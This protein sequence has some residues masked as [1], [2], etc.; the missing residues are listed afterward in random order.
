[1][2]ANSVQHRNI[3]QPTSNQLVDS[4]A[5][6]LMHLLPLP[7][8]RAPT[9]PLLRAVGLPLKSSRMNVA[10]CAR[11]VRLLSSAMSPSSALAAAVKSA[12]A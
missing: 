1:M 9:S 10:P 3:R 12:S 2:C 5:R 8:P 4:N 11:P 7:A 6:L